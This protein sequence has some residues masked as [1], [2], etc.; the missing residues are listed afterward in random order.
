VAG[1]PRSA[2]VLGPFALLAVAAAVPLLSPPDAWVDGALEAWRTC[3][4][5]LLA[6]RVS[7]LV[8][9]VGVGLLAVAVVRALWRGR[10]MPLE[11]AWVLA[12]LGAGVLLVGGLKDFLDRPRPGAE[13]LDPG[14]GSF[15]SGHPDARWRRASTLV[16]LALVILARLA[17]AQGWKIA[18]PAG[19]EASRTAP[20]EYVAFG[21]AYAR[22]WLR[23][24]WALDGP[25]AR[26]RSAW[27]RSDAGE[28]VLPAPAL[29]VDEVRLVARPRS[30]LAPHMCPRLRVALNGRVLGEPVLRLGWRAYVFPTAAEDFRAG[31]N[32]LTMEVRG[33]A[34]APGG[35]TARRAAFS[36][37]SL[38]AAGAPSP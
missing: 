13:F 2:G 6:E 25:D 1:G 7:D 3:G 26:R 18:F 28:V 15:P 29:S 9:P 31:S 4:G 14:G 35:T 20:M 23:G 24:E 33:D 30:D 38:H 36:E 12:A 27:L 10:P 5:L 32:V 8:M 37:L 17:V 11:I 19:T 22:G 34:A 16:G 21:T